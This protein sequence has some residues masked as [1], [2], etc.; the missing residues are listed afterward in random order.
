MF[1]K[2][3]IWQKIA[4]FK[5]ILSSIIIAETPNLSKV[6]IVNGKCSNLP[7]LSPSNINGFV[8][9]SNKSP[10]L[11]NREEKS[12]AW[13]SGLPLT[14][15]SVRLDDHIASNSS[16][17]PFFS[18]FVF[19]AIKPDSGLWHSKTLTNFLLSRILLN[20]VTLEA[21]VNSAS[22]DLIEVDD[23]FFVYLGSI[24]FPFHFFKVEIT[25][26]LVFFWTPVFQSSP[27]TT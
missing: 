12:K 4:F 11:L 22:L 3:L 5:P 10:R 9:T 24:N 16:T 15:E 17:L 23:I 18:T 7:P 21:G 6:L 14:L 20:V 26:L 19:S 13:L 25:W 2:Q 1:I 8:V 27:C